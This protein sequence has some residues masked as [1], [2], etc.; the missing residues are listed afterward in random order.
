MSTRGVVW[1]L[2]NNA[3]EEPMCYVD[4]TEALNAAEFARET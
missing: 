2:V 1:R 4:A 3:N